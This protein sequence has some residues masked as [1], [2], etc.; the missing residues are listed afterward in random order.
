MR[1]SE[2]LDT[3]TNA[4]NILKQKTDDLKKSFDEKTQPNVKKAEEIQNSL[5]ERSDSVQKKAEEVTN[6]TQHLLD[7][8]NHGLDSLNRINKS[9]SGNIQ[10]NHNQN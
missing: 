10:N 7:S 3:L 6:G 1:L 8:A 5:I 2:R 4:T 9:I